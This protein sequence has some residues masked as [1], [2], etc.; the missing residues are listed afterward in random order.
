[1]MKH[2]HNQIEKQTSHNLVIVIGIA[3]LLISKLGT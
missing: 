3:F 2:L 1:M